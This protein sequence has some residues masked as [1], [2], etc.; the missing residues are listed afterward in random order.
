M[1]L[2][3]FSVTCSLRQTAGGVP[4]I[5][6]G[7]FNADSARS[8]VLTSV[9]ASG[10]WT[11]LAV[12]AAQVRGSLPDLTC[13]VS[14]TS[15]GSRIDF[16]FANRVAATAFRDLR[17]I[18]DAA[19][20]THRPIT[21][22]LHLPVFG[23]K[24]LRVVRPLPFPVDQ[25]A[26]W[27]RHNEEHLASTIWQAFTTPCEESCRSFDTNKLWELFGRAAEDYLLQRSGTALSG[28]Q[29]RYRGRGQERPP[30][31]GVLGARE[32][33]EFGGGMPT[34]LTGSL[35][36]LGR[37]NEYIRWRTRHAYVLASFS[38]RKLL[39][40][41]RADLESHVGDRPS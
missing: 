25:W 39:D 11:D 13:F 20:P 41:I 36:L 14:P 4:V 37:V 1:Q 33:P 23:T 32:G 16:I 3:T 15:P 38:V 24:I 17:V 31:A 5:I 6:A 21:V 8:A 28:P 27:S 10:Q 34:A 18:T 19:L 9:T 35:R 12:A 40:N 26:A 30:R 22:T 7:D 29:R 2:R